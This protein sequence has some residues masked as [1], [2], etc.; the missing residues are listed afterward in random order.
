MTAIL[1]VPSK[2]KTTLYLTEENRVRL[3]QLPKSNM[4]TLINEAI[5]EKLAKIEREQ[6]KQALLTA[7]ING[8]RTAA[9]GISTQAVSQQIR[10][11]AIA[12][13]VVR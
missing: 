8:K 1:A 7:L 2:Y 5:A 13:R 12:N 9:N 10:E 4:T 11:Q 3:A 6:A